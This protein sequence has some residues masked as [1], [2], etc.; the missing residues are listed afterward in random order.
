M[1]EGKNREYSRKAI[2]N[3][4]TK[5]IERLQT[6]IDFS[7]SHKTPYVIKD[8]ILYGSYVNSKKEKC[9]DVDVAIGLTKKGDLLDAYYS[10]LEDM[11]KAYPEFYE[12]LGTKI[13]TKYYN[14]SMINQ[15]MKEALLM[16]LTKGL[17]ILSV[18]QIYDYDNDVSLKDTHYFMVK[19]GLFNQSEV[20]E[21]SK[22]AKLSETE[23]DETQE[24]IQIVPAKL[25]DKKTD[26]S[27]YTRGVFH[28]YVSKVLPGRYTAGSRILDFFEYY[29]DDYGNTKYLRKIKTEKLQKTIEMVSAVYSHYLGMEL[30][31]KL[32]KEYAEMSPDP[33]YEQS[34]DG[35]HV[36]WAQRGRTQVGKYS[37]STTVNLV[38]PHIRNNYYMYVQFI[39]DEYVNKYYVRC[40]SSDRPYETSKQTNNLC[41]P[42]D[43]RY[44]SDLK[45]LIGVADKMIEL[46][47]NNTPDNFLEIRKQVERFEFKD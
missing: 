44:T 4:L 33:V 27:L 16:D 24:P 11:E 41:M 2:N 43:K 47:T 9:H 1:A 23:S 28:N 8:V 14:A 20:K 42:K 31:P 22:Y 46:L 17:N 45:N 38:I 26:L 39:Y 12:L 19:D 34:D 13:E 18:H 29:I 7:N 30:T 15:P 37:L 5:F 25:P 3:Q 32:F 6:Y 36:W 35:T 21:L 10:S 40:S